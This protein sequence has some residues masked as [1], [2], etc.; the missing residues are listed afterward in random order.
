MTGGVLGQAAGHGAG[1]PAPGVLRPVTPVAS[2]LLAGNPSPMTLEGTN[3]WLL[4]SRPDGPAVVVDPGPDDAEHLGRVAAGG[5]VELIL[6]THKHNDHTGGIDRLRRL[7]GDPP[8]RAADPAYCRDA[9]PLTDGEPITA[10]GVPLRVLATPGHSSDSVCFVLPD[11]VLTGDTVLGRGTTV[12]VHPDGALG[13]YLDSLERLSR[14]AAGT[15][16]LPAHGPERPDL[17]EVVGFYQRHRQ[18]RLRQVRDAV[19]TLGPEATPRQ[20]VELVY[21]EVDRA[22]WDAA[23]WSVSAQLEY[24]RVAGPA[25]RLA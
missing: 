16:V 21:A 25:D 14:F 11:A 20:V 9:A 6:I 18:E 12:V 19:R 15:T 13:P 17:T 8:V 5:P 24:L 10:A 7:A 1:H 2:V 3:T 23:E 22:V 4:R